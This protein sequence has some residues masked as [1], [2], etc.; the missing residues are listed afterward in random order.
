VEAQ[1][2]TARSDGTLAALPMAAALVLWIARWLPLEFA[3]AP[4]EFGIVSLATLQRY[5]QQQETFWLLFALGVGTLLAWLL[6]RGLRG[7]GVP[8]EALGAAALLA[9]LWLPPAVAVVLGL[10]AIG[11]ALACAAR[12]GTDLPQESPALLSPGRATLLV[13]GA[14]LL[15]LALTP[16][17]WVNLWNVAHAVPDPART[18]DTFVFQGE[19]GQ[20]LAW[21]DALRRGGF[22]GKDFFCLYG[23][24]YDLGGAALWGL[25]GRSIAG[26]EL[27]FSITRVLALLA[28]LLLGAALLRRRAWLLLLPCLVPWINLRIG[29]AL[30]GL[31]FLGAWL[32]RGR[33]VWAALAGISGGMALLYSQ[34]FGLAFVLCAALA[35]ALYR[36]WRPALL[37]A[38]GLAAVVTPLAAWYAANGALG[39]ML[40]DVVAY[41]GYVMAGYGK[42]PFPALTQR[43]PL[44]A[45]SWGTRE[46]LALQLG[47]GV[48]AICLG[49][50]L[51]AL[52][53]GRLDPR[54]PLSSAR[55]L[56]TSLRADSWRLL[57]ALTA[58]F[59]LLSFRTALGRSDLVHMI[60]TL[61]AAA[62]LVAVACDRVL[63]LWRA[64][65]GLRRL[66]AWRSL[67]LLLLLLH[68]GLLVA[69]T[70]LRNL[71]Q[72]AQNVTTLLREGNH[73]V[74]SR[75][76]MRVVRW[77]QLHSEPTDPVL[78]LPNNAAYYY[79]MDRP[80][81]IRFVMGH[82]IVTQE[83]RRE[84]LEALRARPPRFIVWDHDAM[85]VDGIADELV[86]G[87]ALLDWIA[88]NYAEE[89][90]LGSVQILAP[91]QA[92]EARA[93]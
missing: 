38:A 11:G 74:G 14:L 12:S 84:V 59:G 26:W 80:S 67:A 47:Y 25:V 5:P 32:R 64:G 1:G 91:R 48:P 9:S 24:F 75:R 56:L 10:A 54:R 58:L 3:Y 28:L 36:E 17:L 61:P 88:A 82:Q 34:E 71:G 31:V 52:R 20:H 70:P 87:E 86:F 69:P 45:S 73:P 50:L 35:F 29:L 78:F 68:A 15:A 33:L 53:V 27:Y 93:P 60:A 62:L 51:L 41:P 8:A 57:V 18:G 13:V 6:A 46:L 90:K 44:E 2:V 66:A 16:Q 49:A 19:I 43:L 22:H 77:I 42:L 85:R 37:F 89:T 30:F 72:S 63:G 83:H 79:L 21:A 65:A 81:P 23:P 40:R 39:P 7:G 92:A 4:N 55:E 76:V